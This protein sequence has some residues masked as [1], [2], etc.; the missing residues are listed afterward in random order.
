MVN[1]NDTLEDINRRLQEIP[2][3]ISIVSNRNPQSILLEQLKD[4]QNMLK[5]AKE[6]KE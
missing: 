1:P 5:E 3:D 2:V 6:K 4:E